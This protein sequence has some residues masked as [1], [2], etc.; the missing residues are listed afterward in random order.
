MEPDGLIR[1][2]VGDLVSLGPLRRELVPLYHRW[3]NDF[4]VIR[5]LG[6]RFTPMTE[7]AE[8]A[9]FEGASHNYSAVH[10]TVYENEH[11]KPIGVTSLTQIDHQHRRATFGISLGE[12]SD[13]G[14]GYGTETTRLMVQY[15]FVGLDLHNINLTV[16]PFNER[17]IRA[18][19]RAGFRETG[20][21]REA[22]RIAGK[23]YDVISMD[24]LASE[25]PPGPL[26]RFVPPG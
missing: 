10:F 8:A 5:T 1:N 14:K 17:G 9:W 6:A 3:M 24:C 4:E 25:Q 26:G 22:V 15:G 20:R 18:Y 7:D 13:W 21:R 16:L 2:I 23:A 19:L 11:G 12:K